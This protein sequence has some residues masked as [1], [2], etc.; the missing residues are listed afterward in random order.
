MSRNASIA[1]TIITVLCCACPGLVMCVFGGLIGAGVPLTTT[2]NDVS[3]VQTLPASYGVGLICLSVILI[4]IPVAVG[5][6]TLRKKP[7]AVES[8]VVPPNEQVPPAS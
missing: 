5:F 2:L 4:L 8:P 3:S 1:V 6:F 7:A